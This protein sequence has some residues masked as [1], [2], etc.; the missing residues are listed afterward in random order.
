MDAGVFGGAV[1]VALAILV[2]AA[3][4][5]LALSRAA[6]RLANSFDGFIG[7]DGRTV[8]VTWEELIANQI[9][10]E[11]EDLGPLELDQPGVLY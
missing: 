8:A 10:G 5:C 4:V 6:T 9:S 7:E 3:L 11:D 2:A 1:V